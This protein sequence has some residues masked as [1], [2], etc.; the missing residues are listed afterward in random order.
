[1]WRARST[2]YGGLKSVDYLYYKIK[3]LCGI[4]IMKKSY[5]FEKSLIYFLS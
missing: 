2:T 1:M 4:K 3:H 5:T